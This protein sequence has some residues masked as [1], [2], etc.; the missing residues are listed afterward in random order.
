MKK[1]A[2]VKLG[3]LG[4]GGVEKYLQTLACNLDKFEVDYYYTEGIKLIGSNWLPYHPGTDPIRKK[5]MEDS[6]VNLIKV[7]A[8]ARDDRNGPPYPWVNTNFFEIFDESKYSV[9]QTAKLGYKDFPFCEMQN[10]N[11]VDSIHSLGNCDI[12]KS[13][14]I[15]KTVLMSQYQ[16]DCWIKNGGDANKVVIIPPIVIFPKE[17]S[18]ATK[19]DFGINDDVF[20]FGMHQSNR[21]D[22]FSSIPLEAYKQIEND[23]TMFMIMGGSPEYQNQARRLNIQNIKFIDFSSDMETVNNFVS[24]LDVFT[25]GRNDG[26]VCSAAIIEALYHGKTVISHPGHNMGHKYQI[27]G[28]G[29]MVNSSQEYFE[30]MKKLMNDKVLLEEM[31]LKSR[32]KYDEKFSFNVC[33]DQYTQI[34]EEVGK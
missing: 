22:V 27:E 10:S 23:K 9:V 29:F 31:S 4:G 14:A 13:D 25:H 24:V 32:Q 16:A 5:Y 1:I 17:K 18:K 19:K 8:E 7:E 30:T 6:R 20:V 3:G 2:F 28:C 21:A 15:K 12:F 33:I 34:Y 11:F 26:E